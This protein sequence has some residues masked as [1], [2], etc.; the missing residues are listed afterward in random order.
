MRPLREEPRS[1]FVTCPT[2]WLH[3][4]DHIGSLNRLAFHDSQSKNHDT[5]PSWVAQH[6]W[7]TPERGPLTSAKSYDMRRPRSSSRSESTI[8]PPSRINVAIVRGATDDARPGSL[9]PQSVQKC[10]MSSVVLDPTVALRQRLSVRSDRASSLSPAGA[11]PGTSAS[12]SFQSST[13]RCAVMTRCTHAAKYP[14]RPAAV[15][16]GRR[17]S[18]EDHQSDDHRG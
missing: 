16:S 13:C 9:P 2:C 5:T 11:C 4:S 1:G 3:V 12:G 6:I 8:L 17:R 14:D 18:E 15:Q 7:L 10:E